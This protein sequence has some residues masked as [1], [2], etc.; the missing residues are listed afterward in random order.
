MSLLY[1]CILKYLDINVIK[2]N[3]AIYSFIDMLEPNVAAEWLH[4]MMSHELAS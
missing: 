2:I 1:Q 3:Y 4:S